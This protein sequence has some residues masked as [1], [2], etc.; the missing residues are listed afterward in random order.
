MRRSKRA[1]G[2]TE[3]IPLDGD[4]VPCN[5]LRALVRAAA[6][7]C[8]DSVTTRLL[9]WRLDG[10]PVVFFR[11]AEPPE[12]IGGALPWLTLVLASPSLQSM[13]EPCALV[14]WLLSALLLV[15]QAL[16]TDVEAAWAAAWATAVATADTTEV[17]TPPLEPSLAVW[18][19]TAVETPNDADG[20]RA[21]AFDLRLFGS[22][23]LRFG[24]CAD[25]LFIP[26]GQI[27]TWSIQSLTKDYTN[28]LEETV[29]GSLSFQII[30]SN[31]NDWPKIFLNF[32]ISSRMFSLVKAYWESN[33]S[34]M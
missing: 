1:T 12:P 28:Y 17:L 33:V 9:D 19:A 24:C 4:P 13:D 20:G 21:N 32:P 14:G 29:V 11:R 6:W 18:S 30:G 16:A 2:K 31:E 15:Q 27:T 7:I 23:S 34:M 22:F 3:G 5:E 8:R 25:K 10:W 26:Y